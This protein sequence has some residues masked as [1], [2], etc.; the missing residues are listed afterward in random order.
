MRY[1]IAIALLAFSLQEKADWVDND[2]TDIIDKVKAIYN[3]VTGDVKDTA[4]DLRRQL[5]SLQQNGDTVKE[6]VDDALVLLQNRR[7]PFLDFVNGGTGRCG[8]GSSCW[9]FRT[10][11][12]DFVLNMADLKTRFPQIEKNGLGDGEAAAD[13][14]DHL[15]PLVLFG[16]YDILRRVPSWQD[17][18]TD[19]ADLYDEIGDPDAFSLELPGGRQASAVTLATVRPL[20]A[21]ILFEP[22]ATITDLFCSKGKQ[23]TWDAVRLNRLR[24]FFLLIKSIFDDGS[25][26]AP[27]WYP[28]TL[29]GEGAAVPIPLKGV[30]KGVADGVDA[31]LAAVDAHLSNLGLCRQIETDVAQ[32]VPLVEY[33]TAKGV[34]NAY[35]VVYGILG[36]QRGSGVDETR[37]T[38]Q[39]LAAA[40]LIRN[41][42]WKEAYSSICDAYALL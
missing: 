16:L 7:T 31:I 8:Q 9:T 41:S 3:E 29:V 20:S 32:R 27:D 36:V 37:A 13:I 38:A 15:P 4:H 26:Y 28:I 33:R 1:F 35:W 21:S 2:I 24:A 25:E 30:F 10:D 22:P 12:E 5:G 40:N 14:I 34:R 11:L 19:L 23:R 18:P 6:T 42:K 39:L 17:V